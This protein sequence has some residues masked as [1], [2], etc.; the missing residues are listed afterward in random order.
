MSAILNDARIK[1]ILQP[2][3]G[4]EIGTR[5]SAECE[6]LFLINHTEREKVLEFAEEGQE[7]LTHK[8]AGKS[9]QLE[10]FGVSVIK[11]SRAPAK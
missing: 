5:E 10:P 7:L 4:V 6:L 1:G 11:L 3:E 8:P 2:P 9:I